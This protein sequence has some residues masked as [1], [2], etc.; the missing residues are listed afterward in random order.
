MKKNKKSIWIKVIA[1][2]M[3]FMIAI[4]STVTIDKVQANA[5]TELKVHL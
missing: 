5:A 2:C 1:F 4:C 3:S